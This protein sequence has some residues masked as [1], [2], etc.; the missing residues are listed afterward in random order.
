VI[1]PN[2]E[3]PGLVEA[4]MA[5]R[6]L[7]AGDPDTAREIAER[8]ISFGRG[9]TIEE[10]FYE[11]PILVEALA[12]LGRWDDLEAALRD[13]RSRPPTSRGSKPPSIVRRGCGSG[14]W[15]T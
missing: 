1:F 4:W 12:A 10:P 8:L 3:E 11:L 14:L 5:E 15:V 9:L 13:I 2:P 7:L 6:A